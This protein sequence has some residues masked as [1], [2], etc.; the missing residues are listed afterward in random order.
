MA[1]TIKFFDEMQNASNV[2]G[3]D[4]MMI[5]KAESGET[6]VI[7]FD[8]AKQYLDITSNEIAPIVGGDSE[9]NATVVPAGPAGQT[10]RADVAP[11]WI[12]FGD[13]PIEAAATNRWMAYWDGSSW[14]LVDMGEL[15]AVPTNGII[16]PGETRPVSGDT[17]FPVK[18]K[19]D[20]AVKL[21]NYFN[22]D[23]LL[24]NLTVNTTL[25][26]TGETAEVTTTAGSIAAYIPIS[27]N[28]NYYIDG[29]EGFDVV[30]RR[31]ALFTDIDNFGHSSNNRVTMRSF[32]S[33]N[34][35]Y[36]VIIVRH[37]ADGQMADLNT[38]HIVEGDEA[39]DEYVPYGPLYVDLGVSGEV[40]DDDHRA[41]DGDKVKK[42]LD[43]LKEDITSI[44]D[45]INQVMYV[46]NI[47]DKENNLIVG[48]IQTASG[49]GAGIQDGDGVLA[50]VKVEK[51]TDYT[52]SGTPAFNVAGRRGGL[53]KDI[54]TFQRDANNR[55]NTRTFNSGDNEYFIFGVQYLQDEMEDLDTI[56]VEEGTEATDYTPY[57]QVVLRQEPLPVDQKIVLFTGASF[58]YPGNPWVQMAINKLGGVGYNKAISGENITH[59]ASKMYNGTL[60]SF[61]E[62]ESFEYFFIMQTHN[63][64][65]ADMTGI[66][67][68]YTDYEPVV[69]NEIPR[70]QAFDYVLKKY[71]ADCYNLKDDPDSKWYG[72]P[73][74]KP[75]NIIVTTDYHDARTVYNEAVRELRDRHGFHLLEMD[76]NI[77]FSKN[78]VH[79]VT[80]QQVSI[81][82]AVDT[83]QISG[84][85]YGWHPI[86]EPENPVQIM[87]ANLVV[88][89]VKGI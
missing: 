42:S 25:D 7:T 77:G 44:D 27:P 48:K 75:C 59:T 29:Y 6:Q 73:Y 33:G 64:D 69:A 5:G 87:I 83:Q 35:N 63:N 53:Y 22:P 71:R 51:N 26:P 31:L 24:E 15:P 54:E 61:A 10:R 45:M 20:K 30:G 57:G 78:Q 40:I 9:A 28:T 55:I 76:K 84:V 66:Q 47:F 36:L 4:R 41:V 70:N 34:N 81:I 56:Q 65:V 39:P 72:T 88:N 74:G 21:A 68:D 18:D 89:F 52:L 50:W 12:D 80:G 19:L 16:E 79:P 85:T 23:N 8:Q 11:G 37:L 60:Y 14:S 46:K 67:E 62:M 3:Q 58:T 1:G 86:R 82:Y 17:V 32:N 38:I 2:S 49:D 43:P 13:G